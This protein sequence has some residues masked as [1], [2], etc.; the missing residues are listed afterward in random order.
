MNTTSESLLLRLSDHSSVTRSDAWV[1]F[2]KLYTPLIFYWA[3]KTGLQAQDAADLVQDVMAIV[4]RR[5]ASFEYDSGKSFRGWLR[6][7]TLNQYRQKLRKQKLNAID[8]S[9]S[10]LDAQPDSNRAEKT[11]DEEYARSLL[12]NAMKMAQPDFTPRTWKALEMLL[13]SGRPVA[14]V[15]VELEMRPSTLYSAKARLMRRLKKQ[16][17]GLF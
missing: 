6:T 4:L 3:R 16:L 15:A 17:D 12:Q 9:A 5:I 2:T 1:R 14:E 11:W 8:A 10:F 7:V 13:K